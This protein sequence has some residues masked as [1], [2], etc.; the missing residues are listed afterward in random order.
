MYN[1]S[2]FKEKDQQTILNFIEENPFAF[3]TGSFAS[4]KQVAS[5][6]PML[7]EERDGEL[8]LQGHIMR[9]TDHHQA[10]IENPKEVF[11]KMCYLL[12][13]EFL[14]IFTYFHAWWNIRKQGKWSTR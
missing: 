2:Y 12:L 13:Y 11:Y 4:G 8:F 14:F 10:F 6:I 1:F 5:Q 7:L 3:I 9:N